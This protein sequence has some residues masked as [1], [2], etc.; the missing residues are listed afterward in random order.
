MKASKTLIDDEIRDEFEQSFNQAKS[1]KTLSDF[2]NRPEEQGTKKDIDNHMRYMQR[3]GH[4]YDL[5]IWEETSEN[6]AKR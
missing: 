5:S 4:A 3:H 1:E 2:L 6:P